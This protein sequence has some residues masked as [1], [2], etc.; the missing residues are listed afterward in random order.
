M[1]ELALPLGRERSAVWLGD[2]PVHVPFH[3]VDRGAREDL[4]NRRLEMVDDLGSGEVEHQLLAALRPR[5]ARRADRPVR[6]TLEQAAAR[7]DHLGLDPQAELEAQRLDLRRQRAKPAR[8]LAPINDP[9]AERAVVAVSLAEP[10]VVEDEQLDAEV[11]GR[12]VPS[13]RASRGR[14]RSRRPPSC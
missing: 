2:V 6:V 10:A 9:V 13:R 3:V 8:E 12:R 11:R 1:K 14:S 5:P 7:T 4:G